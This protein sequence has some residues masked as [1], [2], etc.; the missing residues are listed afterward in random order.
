MASPSSTSCAAASAAAPQQSYRLLVSRAPARADGVGAGAP[1]RRSSTRPTI[2][3]RR[4]S[5]LH[6]RGGGAL[7]GS[8]NPASPTSAS[9]PSG[10]DPAAARA[11]PGGRAGGGAGTVAR[12]GG[13]APPP[14]SNRRR[15][16]E[17][18]ARLARPP[19]A[20]CAR[21]AAR[22]REPQLLGPR[23]TL[24]EMQDPRPP[25]SPRPP[26]TRPGCQS[27]LPTAC[28]LRLAGRILLLSKRFSRPA[29][30]RS[31]GPVSGQRWHVQ[32]SDTITGASRTCRREPLR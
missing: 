10:A 7:L 26:G 14:R 23:E 28:Q 17:A 15:S 30:H 11:C 25:P 6:P 9:L 2:R 18:A 13:P 1:A 29:R 12:A 19:P 4:R 27:E 22:R 21:A 16:R 20:L 3:A 5:T 8:A 32:V 31:A 24:A